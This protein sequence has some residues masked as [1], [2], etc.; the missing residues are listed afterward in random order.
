MKEIAVEVAVAKKAL[1]CDAAPVDEVAFVIDESSAYY[2]AADYAHGQLTSNFMRLSM[3]GLFRSGA[4]VGLY[5]TSDLPR[6]HD[7]KVLIFPN[8]LAPSPATR[9]EIE[10]LKK[11]GRT[12][13]FFNAPGVYKDGVLDVTSSE[14]LTGLRLSMAPTQQ[15]NVSIGEKSARVLGLAGGLSYGPGTP[16]SPG[17]RISVTPDL[18]AEGALPDGG[19][20][21][22]LRDLRGWTSVYS[23]TGQLPGALWEAIFRRARVHLYAASGDILHASAGCVGLTANSAGTKTVVLPK[24]KHVVEAFTGQDFGETNRV[25]M[26]MAN[27]QTEILLLK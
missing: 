18:T 2:H 14:S 21:F 10:S 4:Q 3:D 15:E 26:D 6:L 11:A 24:T 27:G 16:L 22:A 19:I 25:S 17:P 8:L 1:D 7:K 23:S 13:V 20:G 12:L 9:R 5:N